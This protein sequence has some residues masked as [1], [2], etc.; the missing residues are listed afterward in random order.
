MYISQISSE[1][2]HELLLATTKTSWNN[3][4]TTFKHQSAYIS[5]PDLKFMEVQNEAILSKN[6]W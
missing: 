3:K 1:Q 5:C 2:G 6:T 4:C